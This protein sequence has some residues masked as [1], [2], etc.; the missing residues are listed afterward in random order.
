MRTPMKGKPDF[1]SISDNRLKEYRDL[2]QQMI[3]A[4]KY[5]DEEKTRVMTDIWK[6]L[7]DEYMD[8]LC[9]SDCVK[10]DKQ[11]KEES[12]SNTMHKIKMVKSIKR[13]KC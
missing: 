13:I 7:S 3:F 2:A 5:H 10:L 8:R 1:T 4:Y 6:Q 11:G 9:A 12:A